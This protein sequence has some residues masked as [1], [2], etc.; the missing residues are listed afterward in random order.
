MV[1]IRTA[2]LPEGPWKQATAKVE[3][4]AVFI[5]LVRLN[6]AQSITCSRRLLFSNA[7]HFLVWSTG[8]GLTAFSWR[9]AAIGLRILR[10]N[11]EDCA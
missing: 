2:T 10:K 11:D 1:A 9:E 7:P 4:A 5:V 6:A 8:R 3:L